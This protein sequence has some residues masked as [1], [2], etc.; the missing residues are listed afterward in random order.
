MMSS[1]SPSYDNLVSAAL[2][3]PTSSDSDSLKSEIARVCEAA[4]KG[5]LEPRILGTSSDA[6]LN[7]I[8]NAI[9]SLLDSTDVYVRESTA[10]L[11][12]ASS[13]LYYRRVLDRGMHGAFRSGAGIINSALQDMKAQS[14]QLSHADDDRAELIA[15]LEKTLGESANRISHAI[16]LIS[17]ITKNTRVLAINAKIEASRAGDAGLGFATVAHEVEL[18]SHRVNQVM[19]EIDRVFAAFKAETQEVLK[20]VSSKKAA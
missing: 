4:T 3:P 5:D 18:T 13:G 1:S 11:R 9:N 14:E 15:S 7:A 12:A 19:D 16:Q 20:Q 2:R 8:S 6:D 10:S 17:K